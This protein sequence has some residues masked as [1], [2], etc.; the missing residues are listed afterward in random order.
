MCYVL[1]VG[2]LCA[3]FAPA[4]ARAD[5]SPLPEVAHAQMAAQPGPGLAAIPAGR[6]VG[7]VTPVSLDFPEGRRGEA[8]PGEGSPRAAGQT[9]AAASAHLIRAAYAPRKDTEAKSSSSEIGE[10]DAVEPG[11]TEQK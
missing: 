7:E 1:A 11:D 9:R 4:S 3:V 8:L 10:A 5:T 6:I 2:A